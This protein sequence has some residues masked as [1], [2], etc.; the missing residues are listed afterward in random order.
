ELAFIVRRA[1]DG[2]L[3]DGRVR[4]DATQPVLV[5]QPSQLAAGD[6]AAADVVEPHGLA[7][8]VELLQCIR[9]SSLLLASEADS[10][11]EHPLYVK[12]EHETLPRGARR[13]TDHLVRPGLAPERVAAL[14]QEAVGR[15][16]DAVGPE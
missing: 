13:R 11:D 6:E 2:L 10:L 16:Q 15:P 1:G 7:V 12:V 14:P 5:E 8:P 3:E 9:H 4:G